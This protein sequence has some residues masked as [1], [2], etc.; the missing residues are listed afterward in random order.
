MII[1]TSPVLVTLKRASGNGHPDIIQYSVVYFRLNS[2][3]SNLCNR[4]NDVSKLGNTDFSQLVGKNIANI[5][6]GLLAI[7]TSDWFKPI[8]TIFPQ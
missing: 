4:D 1:D 6:K 3:Y 8:A 7:F 5:L 2:D